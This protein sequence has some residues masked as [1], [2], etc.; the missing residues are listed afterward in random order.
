MGHP[1]RGVL[2]DVEPGYEVSFR[3]SETV[4]DLITVDFQVTWR[5]GT[6]ERSAPAEAPTSVIAVFQKTWG[7]T[8][9]ESMAFVCSSVILSFGKFAETAS[10]E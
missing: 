2:L 10:Y 9:I 4:Y 1:Q 8:V 6:V 3:V 5:E 7:S